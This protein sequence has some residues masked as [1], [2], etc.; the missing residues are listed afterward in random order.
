MGNNIDKFLELSSQGI[1]PYAVLRADSTKRSLFQEDFEVFYEAFTMLGQVD[2]GLPMNVWVNSGH[3]T[4]GIVEEV[5]FQ[6]NRFRFPSRDQGDYAS[7]LLRSFEVVG[8]VKSD[9]SSED[10][11]EE[12]RADYY[13]V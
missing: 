13:R 3:F 10:M 6:T 1:D 8:L 5:V 12:K 4:Q 11:A 2:T 9:L 7:V